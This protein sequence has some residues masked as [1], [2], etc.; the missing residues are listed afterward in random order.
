MKKSP[1]ALIALFSAEFL[2]Y[3]SGYIVHMVAGR[4]LGPL[5]Y[6]RYGLVL[7]ATL[8]V[9]NL[10]GSG[11]PIAMSKFLSESA[12]NDPGRL[13][14]VKRESARAQVI[15]MSLVTAIFFFLAPVFASSLGDPSLAPLFRIAAFIIPAYAA[16]LFYFYLF[17]GMQRLAVQSGLKLAR[18]VLRVVVISAFAFLFHLEGILSAYILVPLGVLA[19]AVMI[20]LFAPAIRRNGAAFPAAQAPFHIRSIF[21]L[22]LPV[23]LF[24]FLFE[25]LISFDIYVLKYLFGSDELAGQY[26]AA[27]TIARVPS[28]LFY[29]LTLILLPSISES[30]AR[31]DRT[32]M[33]ETL[34]IALRFMLII[35]FPFVGFIAAFPESILTLLFGEA[36]APA[37][38]FLPVLAGAA[39]FLAILYV[40]S[41]AYKGT[42]R[43]MT[44][45]RFVGTGL[46]LNLALDFALIPVYGSEA[47]PWIKLGTVLLLTPF[48]LRS[49]R[50]MFDTRLC[51]HETAKLALAT[52]IVFFLARA[53]GDSIPS[54]LIYA[55]PLG[56]LYLV[57]VILFRVVTRDDLALLKRKK[58]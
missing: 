48:F 24:L 15:L 21:T 49:I 11:I 12:E 23:T 44:P 56:L 8:L 39:S 34:R 36:Y 52:G 30:H 32:R 19:V 31:A 33:R 10:V 7:T 22:A 16:D 42:D 50:Q 47:V 4:A 17:S 58:S 40:S 1:L 43:I 13:P 27:L 20:N 51:P 9:A 53:L 5:D 54:L 18:A 45:I 35:A 26:N 37:A 38:R 3:V 46:F 55:I 41:F 2:F 6:G 29:A 57:L 14:I 25:I 28:F